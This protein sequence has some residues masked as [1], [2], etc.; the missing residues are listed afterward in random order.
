MRSFPSTPDI[1]YQPEDGRPE[2]L[3]PV[4][5]GHDDLLAARLVLLAGLLDLDEDGAVLDGDLL[6][7]GRDVDVV[8]GQGGRDRLRFLV[9][10]LAAEQ[11]E[12]SFLRVEE[13]KC[14]DTS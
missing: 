5:P 2:T 6:A 7:R 14:E 9:V 1:L 11:L 12:D 13:R 8:L 3:V 4:G 10:E